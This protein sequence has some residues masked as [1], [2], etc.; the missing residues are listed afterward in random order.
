MRQLDTVLNYL[1]LLLIGAGVLLVVTFFLPTSL[2]NQGKS[3]SA[4]EEFNVPLGPREPFRVAHIE[5]RPESEKVMLKAE[6]PSGKKVEKRHVLAAPKDKMLRLT[7]PAMAR[8][9]N[10]E[11]PTAGGKDEDRLHDYAGIH[12]EGTGFPWQRRANVYIA[13]HRIGYLGTDSL[14]AFYDL[15]KLGP[16]DN[17]FLTDAKDRKYTY[18]VFKR[19]TVSPEDVA[20]TRPIKGRNI[21]TLQT[22]TL[23]NYTQRLIIQAERVKVQEPPPKQASSHQDEAH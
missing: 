7:I 15:N 5:Q 14:F 1:S 22:C 9:E 8:I 13:G 16:G 10:D 3:A 21:V 12:L 17:V 20:V 4:R 18:K 2:W 6:K 19:F 23:P 11:I